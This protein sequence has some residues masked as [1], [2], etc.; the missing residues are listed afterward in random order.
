MKIIVRV[1]NWIGDSILA[2]P[3]IFGLKKNYP[4]SEIWIAAPDWVRDLFE[5]LEVIS[6]VV[7]L[8]QPRS[9]RGLK[10][11]AR[12]I[13]RHGFDAGLLLPNSFVSA[14]LFFLARI[15]QRWGYGTDGRSLMLTKRVS[16]KRKGGESHQVHYYLDLIA[17]LGLETHPPHLSLPVTEETRS[18][19]KAILSANHITLK[20]PVI[21]L[22]P[23]GHYGPAKRWPVPNFGRVSSLLQEEDEYEF[24]LIGSQAEKPL[25]EDLA[26]RMKSPPLNLTGRTT[27]GQLTGIISLSNLFITN[28]SGPMHIANALGIPVIGIF[29]PTRPKITGP[30]QPPCAVLHKE[31]ACWPC[32]YRACPL[33]HR[34]MLSISPE[35][36]FSA[37]LRYLR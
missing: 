37:C 5:P 3:A 34:C 18:E 9:L 20:K 33:D 8:D 25:A 15:P 2:M 12:N 11:S 16:T 31:A 17:G 29:G 10:E 21:I 35:E 27:L 7:S 28:D 4:E 22:N 24:I 19:A 14:L 23:G 13:G 6:G 32:S 1:P 36:V 26:S 30:F